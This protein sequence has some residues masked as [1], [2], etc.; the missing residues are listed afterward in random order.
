MLYAALQ[1]ILVEIGHANPL[2]LM[3]PCDNCEGQFKN[4]FFI[5]FCSWLC[6]TGLFEEVHLNFL[7]PENECDGTFGYINRRMKQRN[8][9]NPKEMRD[10]ID[11]SSKSAKSVPAS[12]VHWYDWKVLL[13]A[14]IKVPSSLEINFYHQLTCRMNHQMF[15]LE[16]LERMLQK[17]SAGIQKLEEVKSGKILRNEYLQKEVCDR[18]CR[19]NDTFSE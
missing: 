9:L 17:F 10:A 18:Y 2:K 5:W 19:G 8:V 6:S 16:R 4:K 14:K 1:M 15:L 13:S 11:E 3:I 12:H 7:V